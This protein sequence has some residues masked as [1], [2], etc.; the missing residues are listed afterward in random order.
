MTKTTSDADRPA[1]DFAPQSLREYALLADGFR[2]A[3]IGPCGDISWLC[4]PVWDSP[5]LFS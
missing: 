3:L 2:G 5:P 4:A 1:S